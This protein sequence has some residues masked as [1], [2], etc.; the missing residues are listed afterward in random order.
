M[1]K[2]RG[3]WL[4]DEGWDRVLAA[5][6]TQRTVVLREGRQ[7]P[8]QEERDESLNLAAAIKTLQ[9]EVAAQLKVRFVDMPK[10]QVK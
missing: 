1:G 7:H 9:D 5:L 8:L 4:T 10:Y 2:K 6:D 3:V